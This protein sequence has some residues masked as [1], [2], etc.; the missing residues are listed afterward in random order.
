MGLQK[1]PH[2]LSNDTMTQ[3]INEANWGL[4]LIVDSTEINSQFFNPKIP[5]KT[6]LLCLIKCILL[7]QQLPLQAKGLFNGNS[8]IKSAKAF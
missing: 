1:N 4:S 3:F 7:L 2:K 6:T 5:K 8:W